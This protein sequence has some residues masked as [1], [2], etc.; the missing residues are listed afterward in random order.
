MRLQEVSHP[1][2]YAICCPLAE[3]LG[4]CCGEVSEGEHGQQ[5][6]NSC[7]VGHPA[8]QGCCLYHLHSRAVGLM[9]LGGDRLTLNFELGAVSLTENARA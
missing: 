6:L 2:H 3:G 5:L 7:V 4:E 9:P 1:L 8:R